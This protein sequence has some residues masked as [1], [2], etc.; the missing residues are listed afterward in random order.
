MKLV[1][2]I[3]QGEMIPKWWGIIRRDYMTDRTI[4][5]PMGL[6]LVLRLADVLY[7]LIANAPLSV[8]EIGFRDGFARGR[9]S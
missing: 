1:R 7:I 9:R 8:Y 4:V 6:N 2:Y 5:A 3:E